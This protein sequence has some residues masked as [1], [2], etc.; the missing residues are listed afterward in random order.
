MQTFNNN[1]D[2]PCT[3]TTVTLQDSNETPT[4]NETNSA[5]IV[6]SLSLESQDRPRVRWSQDTVDN[7]YMNKKKSKS[8]LLVILLKS[9]LYLS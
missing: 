8:N 7:E 4:T 3:T 9:L 1:L 2:Q 5:F 6:G